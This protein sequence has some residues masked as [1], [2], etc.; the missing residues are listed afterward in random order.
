MGAKGIVASTA[1]SA[2]LLQ[3]GIGDAIMAPGIDR[4]VMLLA[5]EPNIRKVI[6]FPKTATATGLM[7]DAPSVLPGAP[8]GAAP[9]DS[10]S[11]LRGSSRELNL[12]CRAAD[13][14]AGPSSSKHGDP[15]RRKTRTAS[16]LSTSL[17]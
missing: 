4:I 2:V 10:R 5:D 16:T 17:F 7:F 6:G 15:A 8:A 13:H 14:S 9:A 3:E 12:H 1:G 11:G